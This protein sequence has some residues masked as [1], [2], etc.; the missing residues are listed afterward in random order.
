MTHTQ[1]RYAFV[2]PELK[3][4][5]VDHQGKQIHLE[6]YCQDELSELAALAID[7]AVKQNMRVLLLDRETNKQL[8]FYSF[9]MV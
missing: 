4:L 2:C 3:T 8:D 6:S 5:T 1:P 7:K 9:L